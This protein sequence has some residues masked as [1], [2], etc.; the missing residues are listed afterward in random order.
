MYLS[1]GH[2]TLK[3]DLVKEYNAQVRFNTWD[4]YR[5]VKLR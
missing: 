3:L 5:L 1:S 4:M 2:C